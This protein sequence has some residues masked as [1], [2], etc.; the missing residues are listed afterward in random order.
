MRRTL[1]G[2]RLLL[3]R[4]REVMAE[5][6][7]PQERLDKIVVLIAA[8]MVAEVCSIYLLRADR[9]LELFATEGLNRT[10]VHRTSLRLGEGLVGL[11]AAEAEPLNL[12]DASTH[13]S[14]AYKPET[15][16]EIYHSFLG[17]PV[18][19]AGQTLGVLVVQNRAKRTY[20][21]EEIEALQTTAM[22]I[23]EMVAAREPGAMFPQANQ[24]DARRTMQIEGQP[25]ADGV[26]LGKVV[27]HEP[28][29]VVTNLI[30]ED[31]NTE[32]DRL[33]AAVDKLRLSLDRMLASR[34]VAHHGEHRD[35]LEAYRMFANDRGWVRRI[36]EAIGNGLTAEAAVEKVQNDTRARM[37]RQTDPY[38][39]E[40]LHD[41]D[42]LTNRL[43]RELVGV[44]LSISAKDLPKDAIIVARNMGAAELLDYERDRVRGLVFEEAGPTSHATIIARALG[45]PAVGQVAGVTSLCES[46]DSI[47]ADGG[48]GIVQL[49]PPTDV[50]NAYAEKVRFRARRQAQYKRLRHRPSVTLDGEE[51]S[52]MLNAGLTVDLPHLEEAGAAGI[53]LFRTEIPFMVAQTFPRMREQ[54]GLYE[55]VISAAGERPVVFRTLDIGGD[56]VLPYLRAVQEENPA[57]GWRAVRLGLDRP[58][59]LRTQ[60][61]ALLRASAGRRLRLMFPMVTETGEFEQARAI[62]ERDKLHLQK[63]GHDIPAEI[64]LGTMIEVPSLLF[65][66]DELFRIVDFAS[67]GSNDLFHFL[68]ATDRGNPRVAER[69]DAMSAPFLRVLKTIVDRAAVADVPLSICGEMAGR[70]LEAMALIALGYR[71]LSMSPSAIGPVKAMLRKLKA[72]ELRA[73]LLPRLE[74]GRWDGDL[75][76]F[77]KSYADDQ[78]IPV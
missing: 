20:T 72:N 22:V 11:I 74:A 62:L 8:N 59:L 5:E 60:Q 51:I 37:M 23:A 33:E 66:L 77:L 75:R 67:V 3:R 70:P 64:K 65:E 21:D 26:G 15:G 49:R 78:N 10:A 63:H 28:R 27:L 29:V 71:T 69:Y 19:R 4:L 39:R 45:I 41:I 43:L 40:R 57:M 54:T 50:Q 30:A 76:L 53:G 52:L 34:D 9:Q 2:P 31:A 44:P 73:R 13:P 58:A 7:S 48:S 35:V 25:L 38:L 16:E 18:L 56:K 24:L 47:I 17:V 32:L 12:T 42:D 1:A 14:F 61:R 46:G 36:E 6:I 55:S 68:T